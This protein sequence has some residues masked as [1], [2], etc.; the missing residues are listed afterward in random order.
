[1]CY[2]P[3]TV[4]LSIIS[5][6][7]GQALVVLMMNARYPLA[8]VIRKLK[9]QRLITYKTWKLHCIPGAAQGGLRLER[10]SVGSGL[11]LS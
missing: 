2:V 5:G 9:K 8:L 3:I 4:K 6:V 10:E 1:M 11:G 7:T